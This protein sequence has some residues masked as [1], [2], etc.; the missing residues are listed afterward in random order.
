MKT[1]FVHGL[2]QNPSSW[3]QTIDRIAIE[4]DFACP[5]LSDMLKNKVVLVYIISIYL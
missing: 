5:N 4:M 2:G 3:E 1:I